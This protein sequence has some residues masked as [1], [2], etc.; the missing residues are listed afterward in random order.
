MA[1]DIV[2]TVEA[3]A[4]EPF[5]EFPADGIAVSLPLSPVGQCLYRIDGIL[6]MTESAVFGDTVKTE[7]G[8]NGSLQF[9][10]VAESGGWR[11]FDY[12]LTPG[13]IDSEWEQLLLNA[14]EERGGHWEQV[15]GGLLCVCI[16][17]KGRK[18]PGP[19]GSA[20][21]ERPARSP[22]AN[23]RNDFL[24]GNFSSKARTSR[25]CNVR[26]EQR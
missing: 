26:A 12:I 24:G 11:T 6:V 16:Y 3:G 17:H 25:R 1:D 9:V 23:K 10:R 8:T 14:L 19:S 18:Q 21:S 4:E 7:P 20:G 15:F 5:D 2:L 22:N 13:K